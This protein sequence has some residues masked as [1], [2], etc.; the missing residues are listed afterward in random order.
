MAIIRTAAPTPPPAAAA[1]GNASGSSRMNR[2]MDE[3]KDE[4]Y[5][6]YEIASG[7]EIKSCNKINK[8]V[9]VYR[10]LGNIM[11]PIITLRT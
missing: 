7:S 4:N 3:W 6:S 9:V 5:F 10:L 1:T 2:Q 11:T 8:P